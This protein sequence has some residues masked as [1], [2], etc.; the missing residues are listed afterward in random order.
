MLLLILSVSKNNVYYTYFVSL[1]VYFIHNTVYLSTKLY[2]AV[3]Y[4]MHQVAY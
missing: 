4:K 3:Y 2:C 1:N